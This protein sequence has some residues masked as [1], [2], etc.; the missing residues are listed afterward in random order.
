[1]LVSG[2]WEPQ[3]ILARKRCIFP[4]KRQERRDSPQRLELVLGALPKHLADP[5]GQVQVALEREAT[6]PEELL[7]RDLLGEQPREVGNREAEGQGRLWAAAG[8]GARPVAVHPDRPAVGRACAVGV[9][10]QLVDD[11]ALEPEREARVELARHAGEDRP[12]G[13]LAAE[14]ALEL[15]VRGP[16]TSLATAP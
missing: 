5:R 14:A 1:M 12:L 6:A 9:V 8:D 4:L 16:R 15:R 7:D 3:S 2:C 13:Q 11:V 10:A